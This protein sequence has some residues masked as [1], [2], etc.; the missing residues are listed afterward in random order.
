MQSIFYEVKRICGSSEHAF[1]FLSELVSRLLPILQSPQ[2]SSSSE[3]FSALSFSRKLERLLQETESSVIR[4]SRGKLKEG[5]LNNG[6]KASSL[7]AKEVSAL[8]LTSTGVSYLHCSSPEMTS[9]GSE[10]FKLLKDN[11]AYQGVIQRVVNIYFSSEVKD[12]AAVLFDLTRLQAISLPFAPLRHHRVIEL[13]V[14][15]LVHPHLKLPSP[16][17]RTA[18][19]LSFISSEDIENTAV[20]SNAMINKEDFFSKVTSKAKDLLQ[21]RDV[22]SALYTLASISKNFEEASL[23]ISLLHKAPIF[24]C[25]LLSF[26]TSCFEDASFYTRTSFLS[27]APCLLQFILLTIRQYPPLHSD[28]FRALR[29]AMSIPSDAI[30]DTMGFIAFQKT[31]LDCFIYLINQGFLLSPMD[32]IIS[33]C[34][35]FDTGSMRH[36]ILHLLASPNPPF[37]LPFVNKIKELLSNESMKNA[38]A[39][40]HFQ[41]EGK[42]ILNKFLD[43][44]EAQGFYELKS[45]RLK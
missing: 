12:D 24:S 44:L 30:T 23:I 26:L 1:L 2:C 27:T 29:T 16:N 45:F 13:L 19:L 22:L 40:K 15:A 42:A 4:G 11:C 32:F 25:C 7:D 6:S 34:H 35:T 36:F 21:L 17:V 5:E 10:L 14:D 33:N 43:L 28:A 37:S 3:E 20:E 38:I 31:L 39:S 9:L 8:K 18:L 41:E